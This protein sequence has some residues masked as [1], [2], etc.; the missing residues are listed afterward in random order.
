[1]LAIMVIWQTIED[2]TWRSNTDLLG[3]IDFRLPDRQSVAMELWNCG[4]TMTDKAD[5]T[6]TYSD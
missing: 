3:I 4:I 1:M 2:A 6:K 5:D